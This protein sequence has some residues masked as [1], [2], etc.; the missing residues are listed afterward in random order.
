MDK[1]VYKHHLTRIIL[2]IVNYCLF[3]NGDVFIRFNGKD[4]KVVLES[5][6]MPP[7][8]TEKMLTRMI[9]N[10]TNKMKPYLYHHIHPK[11]LCF[12]FSH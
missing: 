3:A 11:Q 12:F 1:N 4:D 8:M 9:S 6:I 5:R 10:N 7:E 2:F